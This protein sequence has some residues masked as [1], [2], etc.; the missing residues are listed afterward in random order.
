MSK[1]IYLMSETELMDDILDN[2]FLTLFS[3]GSEETFIIDNLFVD[4]LY[5]SKSFPAKKIILKN[6]V[7]GKDACIAIAF[8]YVGTSRD[9]S[10]D[11]SC[12]IM[13]E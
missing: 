11:N 7:I 12:K 8:K 6:C 1:N 2:K 5:I 10:I 13:T 9:V 4:G 3:S